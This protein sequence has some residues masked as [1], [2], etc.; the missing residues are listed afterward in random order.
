[1]PEHVHL[2][3]SE[4]ER[5]SLSVFVQMLKQMVSSKLNESTTVGGDAACVSD[6]VVV[7]KPAWL[8]HFRLPPL[9]KKREGTGHP[10]CW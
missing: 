5:G 1:M 10:L 2:L 9:R 7:I 8:R 6:F 4:P 3:L